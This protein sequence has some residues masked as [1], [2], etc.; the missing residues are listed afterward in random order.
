MFGFPCHLISFFQMLVKF[1]LKTL[2]LLLEA[3]H[4][5]HIYG[6]AELQKL[7]SILPRPGGRTGEQTGAEA[8]SAA[9]DKTLF[10]A[11]SDC[12]DDIFFTERTGTDG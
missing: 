10:V 4:D 11:F 8:Q 1:R 12:A 7:K 5:N 9:S 6:M 3:A 2:T